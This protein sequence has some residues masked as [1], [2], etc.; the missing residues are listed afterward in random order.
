MKNSTRRSNNSAEI[1][2]IYNLGPTKTQTSISH[3]V[4]S[5]SIMY[6]NAKTKN[7]KKLTPVSGPN[8][9]YSV[10]QKNGTTDS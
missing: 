7:E 4:D 1:T 3:E 10:G 6:G 2:T 8:S 5:A 9:L